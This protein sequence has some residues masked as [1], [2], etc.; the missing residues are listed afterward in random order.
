LPG[1][2][3]SFLPRGSGTAMDLGVLLAMVV[4]AAPV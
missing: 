4:M 2:R 3:C 1:P